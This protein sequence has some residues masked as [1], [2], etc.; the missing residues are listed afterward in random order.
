M[1][2]GRGGTL[3]LTASLIGLSAGGATTRGWAQTQAA[4]GTLM[5][6][7]ITIE[8]TGVPAA[9]TEYVAPTSI[10][11][12]VTEPIDTPQ[13][14]TA[15]TAARIVEEDIWSDL[16]LLNSQPAVQADIREGFVTVRGY[17][18][19]RAINGIPVGSFI[20]RNSAD[21]TPFEQVEVLKGPA[22]LFQ[23]AG[24]FGGVVNYSFKRPLP[25]QQVDT[26]LGRRPPGCEARDGGLQRR[27]S[28]RRPAA[29]AGRGV[30]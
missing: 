12:T 13:T 7:P 14:V 2:P 6:D 29:G 24:G 28:A 23:G 4:D 27:T 5:L 10:N 26:I 16:D 11:R 1:K 8:T 22:A 17:G 21:L 19:D 30:L 15:V 9:E 20:G 25:F 18:A 3:L